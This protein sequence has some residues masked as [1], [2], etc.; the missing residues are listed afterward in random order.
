M[1]YR[2]GILLLLFQADG[3]LCAADSKAELDFSGY[4]PTLGF[5]RCINLHT[6]AARNLQHTNFLVITEFYR[7]DRVGGDMLRYIVTERGQITNYVDDGNGNVGD[8]HSRQV[9]D[10]ELNNLRAAVG[11]LPVTNQ[12]PWIDLLVIISNRNGTNWVTHAYRRSRSPGDESESPALRQ[13][14][15]IV[16]ERPEAKEVHQF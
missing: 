9:S 12:Y 15:Q 8:L 2:F 14:L 4:P 7:M 6:N 3:S 5:L 16:G 11:K 10:V 13:V 1:R